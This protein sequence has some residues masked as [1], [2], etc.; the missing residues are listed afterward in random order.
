MENNEFNS[1][2][3]EFNKLDLLNKKKEIL[4][5]VK[6]LIAPLD[7]L[8]LEQGKDVDYLTT[9][10]VLDIDG[11]FSEDEF[12]EELMV[13]IENAKNMIG[14]YIENDSRRRE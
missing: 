8:M 11:D 9:G 5:S 1:Y 2:I 7:L 14:E 13:N 10:N 6:E 12:L 3:D 4:N